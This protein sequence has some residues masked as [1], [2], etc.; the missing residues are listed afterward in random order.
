VIS[1]FVASLTVNVQSTACG[2]LL[3]TLTKLLGCS[4][5]RWV[6]SDA[7]AR[8]VILR[9]HFFDLL[10]VKFWCRSITQV[11]VA[12]TQERWMP[13]RRKQLPWSTHCLSSLCA[14]KVNP[15]ACSSPA[16]TALPPPLFL[17]RIEGSSLWCR[18]PPSLLPAQLR[19]TCRSLEMCLFIQ[20]RNAPEGSIPDSGS[21]S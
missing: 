10:T 11:P 12:G 21:S 18:R 15:G 1:S 20:M 2:Y 8:K 3:Y 14:L 4:L 6:Q 17:L 16:P 13:G 7:G 9:A 19:I 5:D